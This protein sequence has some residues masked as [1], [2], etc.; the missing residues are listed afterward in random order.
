MSYPR[1]TIS[2]SKIEHNASLVNKLCK[3]RAIDVFGVTK[4]V[5]GSPEVASAMLRGGVS[6]L[7]DSHLRFLKRFR[8]LSFNV[9]LWL[10]RQPMRDEMD[11]AVKT[12]DCCLI[13]EAQAAEELSFA[14]QKAGTSIKL[15]LFLEAGSLREGIRPEEIWSVSQEIERLPHIELAGLAIYRSCR[16]ARGGDAGLVS[17][18]VEA[19]ERLTQLLERELPVVSGGNSSGL[20]LVSSGKIPPAVNNLRL[21]EAILLGH[22]TAEYAPLPNALTDA[23]MLTAEVIESRHKPGPDSTRRIILALGREDL[24]MEPARPVIKSKEVMRSS[25]HLVL[26]LAEDERDVRVG[27][28]VSFVP[29]YFALVAAMVSPFIEK[30]YVD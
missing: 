7:A 23:F 25:S 9:P 18:L 11:E 20:K 22:E 28:T 3:A 26:E 17:K 12:V 30:A 8:E 21:G 13:S 6:G 5:Y 19:H 1:L 29:S 15:L 14:A 10:L 2:L 27:E 24:A 16:K 4:G